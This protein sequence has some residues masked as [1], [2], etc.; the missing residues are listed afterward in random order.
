MK[1]RIFATFDRSRYPDPLSKAQ[2]SLTDEAVANLLASEQMLK[3]VA[4]TVGFNQVTIAA[5]S[6]ADLAEICWYE[7][8]DQPGIKPIFSFYPSKK[9][10]LYLCRYLCSEELPMFVGS[11]AL[12]PASSEAEQEGAA[13]ST[14]NTQLANIDGLK[15]S[16]NEHSYGVRVRQMEEQLVLEYALKQSEEAYIDAF[17]EEHLLNQQALSDGLATQLTST[18]KAKKSYGSTME[19][20]LVQRL[21]RVQAE[22]EQE[23]ENKMKESADYEPN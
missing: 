11:L 3:T 9:F 6:A 5:V 21:I 16:T 2:L 13:V 1:R 4:K 7:A 15:P 23:S 17:G 12:N 22:I 8:L 20:T 18:V 19:P 14:E 10:R